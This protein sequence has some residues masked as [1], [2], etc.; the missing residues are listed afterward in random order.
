[1]RTINIILF[2]LL[3]LF[4]LIGNSKLFAQDT[5]PIVMIYEDTSCKFEGDDVQTLYNSGCLFREDGYIVYST[6]F[7]PQFLL[8]NKIRLPKKYIIWYYTLK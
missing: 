8:P 2:I 4:I 6:Y 1:M 3:I 5:I 7:H